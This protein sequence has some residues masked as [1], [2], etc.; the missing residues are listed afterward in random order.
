MLAFGWLCRLGILGQARI[1]SP[2]VLLVTVAVTLLVVA[3][4]QQ[5]H[6]KW[7]SAHASLRADHSD[8]S[9]HHDGSAG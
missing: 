1:S 8:A 9:H 5:A 6:A 3:A 7:G 2:T 4:V